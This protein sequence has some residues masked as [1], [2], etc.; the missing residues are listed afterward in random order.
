MPLAVAVS[1]FVPATVPSVQLP[2]V[3]IPAASVVCVAPV[4]LPPPEAA[5]N[6]TD[7]PATGLLYWSWTRTAG[8]TVTALP[9]VAP[10]PSPALTL[11]C[12]A[13][14]GDPLAVNVTG[15]PP[16][17]GEVAVRELAP[18]AVPRVQLPTVA[19][20]AASV[21]ALAPVMLPPPDATAKVTA[22][23]GTGL[24]YWSWTITDGGVAT[25]VPTVALWP[26]PALAAICVGASAPTVRLTVTLSGVFDARGAVITTL[27]V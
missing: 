6:V 5:A 1:V 16:R 9:T 19:M 13:A 12:V 21:V 23:P 26:S 17:P 8:A 10:W 11:A 3:A 24:L 14:P 4:T 22:I 25:A 18:A 2:T 27:A 20:P 7:T 15:L